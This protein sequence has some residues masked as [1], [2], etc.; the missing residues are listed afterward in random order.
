MATPQ[1]V[2]VVLNTPGDWDEWI[3]VVK[4]QAIAGDIWEYV[5]PS[6]DQEEIPT[7]DKPKPPRPQDVN[8]EKTIYAQLTPDEKEE[9]RMM[10]QDYKQQFT[11]YERQRTALASL[12]AYIQS[13]VSRNCLYYTFGTETAYEML[14][15]LQKRLQP[16]D[17]LRE[18]DLANRYQKLKEPPKSQDLDT[19]LQSWER[20]YHE[21]LK[22]KLPDVQSGRATRDFLRAI[23]KTAPEFAIFWRNEIAKKEKKK[24]TTPTLNEIIEEFRDHR[25]HLGKEEDRANHSAFS[26]TFQGQPQKETKE[27]TPKKK[28][29]LCGEPHRFKSCPYLI[30][31]RQPQGWKPDPAI[32]E[33]IKAKMQNPRLKTAVDHAR[34]SQKEENEDTLEIKEVIHE[35]GTF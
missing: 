29:C 14:K 3:E 30:K 18:L 26:T 2:S 8:Q 11:L 5:D 12:R 16:T 4:T 22:A 10:R 35:E 33:R 1:K 28:D 24:K 21:C 15:E 13:T 6:R 9:F 19:W 20:I 25:R 23:S 7:L 34:T 32:E 31:E 17:Q 27:E